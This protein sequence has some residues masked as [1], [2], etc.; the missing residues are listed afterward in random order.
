[1]EIGISANTE[2]KMTKASPIVG[3]AADRLSVGRRTWIDAVLI[4]GGALCIAEGW[5]AVGA[6]CVGLGAL[7][8][9]LRWTG[10]SRHRRAASQLVTPEL[11]EAHRE[12]VAA[13]LLPGVVEGSRLVEAA[14]DLILESAALLVGR[15][16]RGAA[17]QRFV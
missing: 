10:R 14:D 3:D 13:A 7:T 4:A 8:P 5:Y 6:A 15:P 2:V 16:A 1:C 12:L 9:L 11:N 17:Q